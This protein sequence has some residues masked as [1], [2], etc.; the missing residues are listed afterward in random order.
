MFVL[1]LSRTHS[2]AA[3]G[4]VVDDSFDRFFRNAVVAETS[5]TPA[6]DVSETDA[7]YIV[8]F[9][10]PGVTREQLKVSVEGRR[11]SIETVDVPKAD[12]AAEGAADAP[13]A[14]AASRSLYRER[15]VARYARTV[16][17]PAEVDQAAS[18]AKV[19]NGVLT[20]TL[21]KKVKAGATQ[22]AIN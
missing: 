11:V 7:A 9:D 8:A 5:R 22:I 2:R 4:R 17:L 10:V 20:L 19:E 21:A 18:Q 15:S 12:A 16:S 6:L 13:Q 1:P 14:D 3:F